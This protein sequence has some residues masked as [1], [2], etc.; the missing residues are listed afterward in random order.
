MTHTS[1]SFAR[2]RQHLLL[3]ESSFSGLSLR[4]SD[5]GVCLTTGSLFDVKRSCQSNFSLRAGVSVGFC[6]FSLS[7]LSG[8]KAK[9]KD[10]TK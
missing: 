9:R 1:G 5:A 8:R 3:L 4:N 6:F 10:V 2:S 7:V